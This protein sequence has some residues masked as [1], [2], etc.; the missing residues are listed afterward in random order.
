[1]PSPDRIRRMMEADIASEAALAAQGRITPAQ[2]R[3]SMR[4]IIEDSNFAMLKEAT[5]ARRLRDIPSEALGALDAHLD[6]Q[7][8]YLDRFAGEWE[9][10]GEWK[11]AFSR[12]AEQYVGSLKVTQGIAAGVVGG[13]AI[14]LEAIPGDGSTPCG[15]A[16]KCRWERVDVDPAAGVVEMYWRLG[17]AEHCSGCLERA[18][19][20]NPLIYWGW[21]R[22]G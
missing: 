21:E 17:S 12:R 7:L 8:A 16:C 15:Q 11:K 5:G 18:S 6:R 4:E 10:T 3:A 2:F 9:R 13:R 20:W 1:M 19:Q 22:V 14:K